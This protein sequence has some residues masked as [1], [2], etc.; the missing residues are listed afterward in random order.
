MRARAH[1]AARPSPLLLIFVATGSLAA[2]DRPNDM[3]FVRGDPGA[4]IAILEV[5][6]FGCSACAQFAQETFPAFYERFIKNG[7]VY[8]RFLPFELGPFRHSRKALRAAVCADDQGSFWPMHDLLYERQRQWQR[9]R[10]PLSVF[11]ELISELALDTVA[12]ERCYDDD[13]TKDRA[14]ALTRRGREFRIRGTPAFRACGRWIYGALPLEQFVE[15]V[16]AVC[17]TSLPPS[18]NPS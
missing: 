7:R 15:A 16:E 8:W 6:D 1:R 11:R 9:T 18:D 14:K 3:E 12:F 5:G 10:N 13:D 4:A 2:Q 17:E